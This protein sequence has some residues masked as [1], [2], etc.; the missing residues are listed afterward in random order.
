MLAGTPIEVVSRTVHEMPAGF[1]LRLECRDGSR[2]VTLQ[3]CVTLEGNV[4]SIHWDDHETG[5][6][7]MPGGL[8]VWR[9]R[10]MV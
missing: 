9:R 8:D 10:R 6:N 2:I 5:R 7:I 4:E 3:I 1:D